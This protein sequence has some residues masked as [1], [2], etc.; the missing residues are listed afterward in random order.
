MPQLRKAFYLFGVVSQ[1]S[2]FV[3][4]RVASSKL[5]SLAFSIR[6]LKDDECPRKLGAFL[7]GDM[8]AL[9]ACALSW[10]GCLFWAKTVENRK[11]SELFTISEIHLSEIHRSS[12]CSWGGRGGLGDDLTVGR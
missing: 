1:S 4:F 8:S 11:H 2:S 6:G 3:R 12:R 7:E 10:L 5:P 9:M